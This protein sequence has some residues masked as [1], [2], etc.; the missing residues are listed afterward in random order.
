MN[1]I[2]GKMRIKAPH[3]IYAYNAVAGFDKSLG[4]LPS[5]ISLHTDPKKPFDSLHWFITSKAQ[6]DRET[7]KIMKLLKPGI[8]VWG[9][10]PKG[11]SKI[12]TD[13]T[14]DKGWEALLAQPDIKWMSLISFD[15]T[16]S[17]FAFRLKTEKDKKEEQ[18]PQQEREIYKYAD[19][20]TKTIR[21]P[22]DLAAALK[23]NKKANEFFQNLAFTHKREYVEWVVTAKREETRKKRVEGVIS[24]LLEGK[25]NRISA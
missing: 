6:V 12:Q 11:T 18:K 23:K 13:L 20:A 14:R 3:S 4:K 15:E 1:N 8:V 10:Y 24:Y 22:H 17:A 16:W 7:P 19:S 25:K 21:L 9:Y 2:L 5:G